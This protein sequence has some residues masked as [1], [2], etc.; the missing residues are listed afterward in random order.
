MPVAKTRFAGGFRDSVEV[1]ARDPH[2]HVRRQTRLFRIS[3]KNVNEHS[4]ST[5]NPVWN[6]R[7]VKRLVKPAHFFEQLLHMY[8]VGSSG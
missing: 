2:I 4:H 1:V 8:V 3:C 5:H 7:I 6:S